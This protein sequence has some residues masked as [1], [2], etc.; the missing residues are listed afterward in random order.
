MAPDAAVAAQPPAAV[1][2][3][4][5]A[6][7]APQASAAVAAQAPTDQWQSGQWWG[8]GHWDAGDWTP[9]FAEAAAGRWEP[10][11]GSGSGAAQEIGSQT[12]A[13]AAVAAQDDGSQTLVIGR[14]GG[15][16]S[17]NAQA[18]GWTAQD[19]GSQT[20]APAAVAAQDDGS[21]T[22][23]PAAVAAQ[24]DGSQT[25]APAAVAAHDEGWTTA[26]AAVAA[27]GDGWFGRTM[28]SPAQLAAMNVT[29]PFSLNNTALKWIRDTHENPRG[30]PTVEEVDLTDSDPLQI[31]VLVKPTQGMDYGFAPGGATQPWSWREMLAAMPQNARARILGD[32]AR[33]VV[34]ITCAPVQGSYDHKRHHAANQLSRPF[35]QTAPVPV[36]DFHVQLDT[37][38][39]VRFHTM[40]KGSNVEVAEIAPA[41]APALP[42]PPRRGKGLSDGRG[43]YRRITEANY[44]PRTRSN[45]PPPRRGG[46]RGGRGGGAGGGGGGGVGSGGGGGGQE[47]VAQAAVAAVVAVIPSAS[48]GGASSSSGGGNLLQDMD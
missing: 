7:V 35:P 10:D 6:V 23:A 9:S 27:Q 11:D 4:P 14:P 38:R 18:M 37:G 15:R 32:P 33:G 45:S 31:G 47:A 41:P 2:E 16:R 43:T 36:W 20:P 48:G 19:D 39:R 3:Q 40:Y 29:Q 22:P 17:A 34:R 24:G 28:A 46:G 13:L 5:S 30:H 44:N 8:D 25:P 26:L 42:G 1:A 21:Q 12:M